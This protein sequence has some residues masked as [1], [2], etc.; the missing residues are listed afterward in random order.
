M[1][2]GTELN[3]YKIKHKNCFCNSYVS[4]EAI[5]INKQFKI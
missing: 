1:A 3:F 4:E 2:S 5:Q